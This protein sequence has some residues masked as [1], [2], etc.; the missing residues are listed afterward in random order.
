[1]KPFDLGSDHSSLR[2][3]LARAEGAL[4]AMEAGVHA[5]DRASRYTPRHL[6]PIRLAWDV[7]AERLADH[8]DAEERMVHP[9]IRHVMGGRESMGSAV[10][11]SVAQMMQAHEEL[12]ELSRQL[13]RVLP[14]CP[15]VAGPIERV[16]DRFHTHAHLEDTR[17]YPEALRVVNQAFQLSDTP[18]PHRQRSIHDLD[19]A[20]R[21]PR[22]AP[23]RHEV[24]DEKPRTWLSSLTKNLTRTR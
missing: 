19:R 24:T 13:R 23:Q 9:A 22:P 21:T 3:A 5:S 15:P 12:D 20:L 1:M 7:F 8:L 17:L 6:R 4:V 11:T 18:V 16:I 10:S 2:D 14:Y